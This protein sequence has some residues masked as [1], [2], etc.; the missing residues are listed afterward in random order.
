MEE[1]LFGQ[2][3][4]TESA[5]GDAIID[6]DPDKSVLIPIK[7]CRDMKQQ[8]MR[9]RLITLLLLLSSMALFIF[10]ICAVLWQRGNSGSSGQNCA[11]KPSP[12]YSKQESVYPTANPQTNIPKLHVDLTSVPADNKTDG[13]YLKWR[14]NFGGQHIKEETAIVI[15]E[16]GFYYV[17]VRIELSCNKGDFN[18]F[19]A[20]L[21]NWSESYPEARPTMKAWDG[22]TS[23]GDKSVFMGQLFE[24][25][26]GDNLRVWIEL[27]YELISTSS[28]GAFLT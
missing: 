12:A 6:M 25:S 5:C 28:F 27:G 15:P 16:D 9:P 3:L 7:H 18:R 23:E 4:P 20:E 24:L 2:T 13:L 11:V 17:Y 14:D 22:C 21:R 26:K 19:Y 8:E 10:T 1:K